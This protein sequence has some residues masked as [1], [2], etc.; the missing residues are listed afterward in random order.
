VRF[1]DEQETR[2]WLDDHSIVH[3]QR[4]CASY[5]ADAW[6][7][8]IRLPVH[9]TRVVFLAGLVLQ[10]SLEGHVGEVLTTPVDW[11]FANDNNFTYDLW[12]A[13]RR[14]HVSDA[15]TLDEKDAQVTGADAIPIMQQFLILPMLEWNWRCTVIPS[16][17]RHF[18][19]VRDGDLY[20]VSPTHE[21]LEKIHDGL[22]YHAFAG[23]P[24][25][26]RQMFLAV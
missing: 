24:E 12:N 23:H 14:A 20:V 18:L 7:I 15:P 3:S 9:Y 19:H 25:P 1:L 26:A 5:P 10:W 11:F 21:E 17:N 13:L 8:R 16:H 22:Q 2:A 6:Q 4:S